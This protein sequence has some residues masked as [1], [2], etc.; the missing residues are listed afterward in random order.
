[1]EQKMKKEPLTGPEWSLGTKEEVERF[2]RVLCKWLRGRSFAAR[3]V[4]DV[5]IIYPAGRGEGT[6]RIRIEDLPS[7]HVV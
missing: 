5:I 6:R 1:M 3:R 2:A 4:R 7:A